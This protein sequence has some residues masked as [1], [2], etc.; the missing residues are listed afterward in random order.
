MQTDAGHQS[1][2]PPLFGSCWRSALDHLNGTCSQLT[3]RSQAALAMRFARCFM[4]MTHGSDAA[5]RPPPAAPGAALRRSAD[6]GAD[7]SD[8][9]DAG[10][11]DIWCERIDDHACMRRLPERHFAAF[12]QFFAHTAHVCYYV[13]GQRWH[14]AAVQQLERMRSETQHVAD[15]MAAA[16]RVQR[17][18]LLAQ[19]EAMRMQRQAARR[20]ESLAAALRDGGDEVRRLGG[21][22]RRVADDQGRVL[23]AVF[24]RVSVVRRRFHPDRQAT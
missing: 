1:G 12:T 22:W 21:E 11:G 10:G 19:R 9:S 18:L 24:G 17:T 7:A 23:A 13:W 2:A 8:A 4:Q 15:Q 5:V 14:A 16:G 3:E 20:A 6:G